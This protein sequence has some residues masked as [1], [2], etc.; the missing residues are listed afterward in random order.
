[1][2]ERHGKLNTLAAFALV[3]NAF[4]WGVSWFFFRQ[5]AAHGVHPVWAT[6]LVY[7][8]IVAGIVLLRRGIWRAFAQYPALMLLALVAG[9]TNVGFNWAV[10]QGDVVRVVLLFY[11]MPLW[12][13]LLAWVFLG[14]RPTGSALARVALALVGVAVVLKTPE[15]EWPLPNSLPDWLG[16]A[17]GF[18]FAATN[19]LL[20][21]L[22]HAPGE[23]RA[24]A[25]FVGGVLVAG[26]TAIAGTAF[27]AMPAPPWTGTG[28]WGWAAA[29]GV[30][31]VLAN[32]CLQYGAAR[33]PGNVTAVIMLSEVL[34]ASVSSVALG[35]AR[36][37]E[38]I[39]IGGALIV[40]AAAWSAFARAP[41]SEDDRRPARQ[42]EAP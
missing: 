39:W 9:L 14:E 26:A 28:W 33:L 10:T 22:R 27:G 8:V 35:A 15:V 1:V 36:M 34:F 19:I 11:L 30:G 38:R 2:F 42:K 5:I 25:M 32:V 16:V 6:F 13:V 20:R 12:V 3:I 40:L 17:A 23:S 7:V 31:F 41:G 18:C 29:L 21:G 4:V 24:L 37:S